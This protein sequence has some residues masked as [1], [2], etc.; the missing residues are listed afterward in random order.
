MKSA[1][2]RI[3]K[4]FSGLSPPARVKNAPT[5]EQ[6]KERLSMT[7][8]KSRAAAKKPQKPVRPAARAKAERSDKER[9]AKVAKPVRPREARPQ[10]KKHAKSARPV[11]R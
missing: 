11:A 9:A 1:L 4:R 8:S 3:L 7:T 2:R 10:D 6:H 5:P